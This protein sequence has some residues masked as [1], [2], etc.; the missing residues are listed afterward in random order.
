MCLETIGASSPRY[1]TQAG[2][3]KKLLIHVQANQY[4]PVFVVPPRGSQ[5]NGNNEEA[6]HPAGATTQLVKNTLLNGPLPTTELQ[7]HIA[8]SKL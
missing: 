7:C 4:A 2:V 6:W 1:V 8:M 5:A 3:D